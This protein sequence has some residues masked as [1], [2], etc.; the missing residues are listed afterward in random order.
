[1]AECPVAVSIDA[2]GSAAAAFAA[3]DIALVDGRRFTFLSPPGTDKF[4]EAELGGAS[5]E[6]PFEGLFP[7][8]GDGV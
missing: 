1:M 3:P 7:I 6:G 5:P 4:D 8:W 2:E